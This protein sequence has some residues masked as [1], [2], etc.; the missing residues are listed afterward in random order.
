MSAN[1]YLQHEE[2]RLHETMPN[3]YDLYLSSCY[4]TKYRVGDKLIISFDSIRKSNEGETA[5]HTITKIYANMINTRGVLVVADKSGKSEN[6]II[7]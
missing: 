7:Q 2:F 4:G 6:I 1:I 3:Q 5:T